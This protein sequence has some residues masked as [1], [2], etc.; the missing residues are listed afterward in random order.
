ML[1]PHEWVITDDY[2][3]GEHVHWVCCPFVLSFTCA[4]KKNKATRVQNRRKSSIIQM[5]AI[6]QIKRR[7]TRKF[8][9]DTA[10]L[11]SVQ[12][13]LGLGN[14]NGEKE[15]RAAKPALWGWRARNKAA[16]AER[17][18]AESF[19]SMQSS[20]WLCRGRSAASF[21]HFQE[22]LDLPASRRPRR[23][24]TGR[25][26]EA[27]RGARRDR[28]LTRGKNIQIKTGPTLANAFGLVHSLR[29]CLRSPGP[30]RGQRAPTHS[31]FPT[32]EG[33]AWTLQPSFRAPLGSKG[34]R[35]ASTSARRVL[36]ENNWT[37]PERNGEW[38]PPRGFPPAPAVCQWG[39]WHFQPADSFSQQAAWLTAELLCMHEYKSANKPFCARPSA[40]P[41]IHFSTEA[42]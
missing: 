36:G 28:C 17:S 18:H 21:G 22:S 38:R 14:G 26:A 11:M 42:E 41:S 9:V 3:G 32:D 23:R 16:L 6:I 34:R 19:S 4:K 27:Q 40:C 24:W 20:S 37:T 31:L 12:E 30:S 7:E 1:I 33:T 5:S 2:A 39:R 25:S 8:F 13:T 10:N 35:P 29:A 15:A